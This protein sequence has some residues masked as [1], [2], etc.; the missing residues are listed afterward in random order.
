MNSFTAMADEWIAKNMPLVQQPQLDQAEQRGMAHHDYEAWS[1]DFAAWRKER[2]A[3][4]EGRDD[5]G[6]VGALL[7]D[8]G[9]WAD[10]HNSLPCTRQVLEALL[11]D[12]GFYVVDGLV[13]GLVLLADLCSTFPDEAAEKAIVRS[14]LAHRDI[15]RNL[16]VEWAKVKAP[17]KV[18]PT[19]GNSVHGQAR[20]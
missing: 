19:G 3:H 18:D 12:A 20:K 5:W 16:S 2:C 10:T 14:G 1:E 7:V 8:F 17:P 6:G 15:P 13:R 11:R 4:R 9:E